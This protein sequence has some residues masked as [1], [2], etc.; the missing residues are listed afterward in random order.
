MTDELMADFT[1]HGDG[2]V[3]ALVPFD[4]LLDGNFCVV[5]QTS[6]AR[7]RYQFFFIVRPVSACSAGGIAG[8]DK[9]F[10]LMTG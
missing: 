1:L 3:E 2:V 9:F 4:E 7:N 10:W 8:F 5:G 6:I